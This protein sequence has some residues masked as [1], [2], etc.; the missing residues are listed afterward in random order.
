[1]TDLQ[2][3]LRKIRSDAAECLMLSNLATEG[4]RELFARIAEHL[5]ALALEIEKTTAVG[6]AADGSA[7]VAPNHEQTVPADH[8]RPAALELEQAAAVRRPARSWWIS[9]AL[10]AGVLV[11]VAGASLLAVDRASRTPQDDMKQAV[12]TILSD[13]GPKGIEAG[14]GRAC[15]ANGWSRASSE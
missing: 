10:L 15:R 9:S 1:M 14:T 12:A 5:N 8:E 2:A 4:K 13:G 7:T 6:G 3:H 11:L